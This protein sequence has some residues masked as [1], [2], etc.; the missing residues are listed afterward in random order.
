M[1]SRFRGIFGHDQSFTVSFRTAFAP[2][3]VSPGYR[4]PLI[5]SCLSETARTANP[6][7]GGENLQA[8]FAQ[9]GRVS[10]TRG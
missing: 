7:R 2:S 9:P 5:E 8:P 10:D 4:S 3:P 6:D 1:G